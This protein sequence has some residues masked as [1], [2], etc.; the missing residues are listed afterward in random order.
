MVSKGRATNGTAIVGVADH[1]GWAVLMTVT[2]D[3]TV[4]DRRRVE[5]VDEGLPSLPHHHECQK[6]PVDEAVALVA[7]V[8]R[9]A[10]GRARAALDALAESVPARI[11]G[12]SLRVCPPLPDTVA[13]RI[14]SYYAQNRADSVMFREALAEAAAKKSWAVHWYDVKRVFSEAARALGRSSVEDLLEEAGAALGPPWQK[15][16]RVAM[17]AAIAAATK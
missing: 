10:D 11:V 17:A 8:R 13:E 14:S 16:H 2:P 4:L 15:D 5:L 6:L 7:R 1:C 3:G 9:S 12:M